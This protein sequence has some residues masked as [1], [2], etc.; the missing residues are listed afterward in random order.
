MPK[1]TPPN[2]PPPTRP[3]TLVETDEDIRR[4]ELANKAAVP[5]AKKADAIP[6]AKPAA[7]QPY[8][9]TLRPSI[10]VLTVFDDGKTEGETI[11]IRSGRFVIGRTEGDLLIPHDEQISSK[12]IE[13]S[14]QTIGGVQRWVVTDLQSTNGLFLRVSR[15]VLADRS[16]FLVGKGRFRFEQAGTHSSET[17]DYAGSTPVPAGTVGFGD[18]NPAELHPALVELVTSGI[19]NR[20]MLARPEY[21]IG[22]DA[23]CAIC[24]P[25][26]PFTEPKHVRLFRDPKG[27]WTAQNNKT[28]NG[29]WIKVP[30]VTAED[31]CLLQIGEQ[32]LRLKV[33]G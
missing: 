18:I 27:P 5:L 17:A 12:H 10:C 19:G 8:R 11:R 25:Q 6:T 13:I 7:A 15:T 4:A 1:L 24:R 30:Q 28:L 9:P 33:G 29:L 23:S 32:R 14:R 20:I 22:T 21:W 2:D 31:G 26:D 16:E 3:G